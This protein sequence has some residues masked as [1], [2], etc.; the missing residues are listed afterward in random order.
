MSCF[1]TDLTLEEILE[2]KKPKK[3][4]EKSKVPTEVKVPPEVIDTRGMTPGTWSSFGGVA[5]GLDYPL[6]TT[7]P[8]STGPMQQIKPSSV[9]NRSDQDKELTNSSL[10]TKK[11][12]SKIQKLTFKKVVPYG[13]E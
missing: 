5:E 13:I 11:L 12:L 3:P 1:K 10:R 8:I 6:T 4:Y 9:D 2:G 7:G